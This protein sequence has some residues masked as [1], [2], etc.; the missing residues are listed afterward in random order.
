MRFLGISFIVILLFTSC[1][2]ASTKDFVL[3]ENS[4]EK[5]K[6]P[7]FADHSKDYVYKANFEVYGRTFGGLL[8]IKKLATEHHRVV[9]ATE[10]GSKMMDMELKNDVFTINFIADDLNK[11]ILINTLKKD[12]K[13]LLQEE[14]RVDKTYRTTAATIFQLVDNK[15]F[16]YYYISKKNQQLVRILYAS[17]S[18]EKIIFTFESKKG[19][20]AENILID[21]KNMKLKIKL[22][23]ID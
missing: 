14:I 6:N 20:I 10:F 2:V 22:K 15:R 21:H 7:Y 5:Y 13:I 18:K 16:N 17:K 3:V 23:R 4:V 11:K 19:K 12:F 1:T 8:I 9:F